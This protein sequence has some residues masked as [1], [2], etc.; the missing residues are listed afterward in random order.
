M[1]RIAVYFFYDKDG[2]VD[3]YVEYLLNDFKKNVD[4][5]IIVCN[6]KLN[7]QGKTSLEKFGDVIVRE[8]K[9]F[10]VWAY[11]TGLEYIGWDN[12]TN[13]DELILLNNTIYGPI[14]PFKDTFRK[15]EK[16]PEL[17]FWGLTIFFE[18]KEGDPF[19]TISCG[20]I[21]DHIQSHF[22]AIRKAMFTSKEFKEYWENMPMINNYIESV[23]VHE[24]I[25]TKHFED[26]GYKWDI[27]VPMKN[28][29]NYNCNPII[30]CPQKL[31]AEYSC[32][33]FKRRSF[34][35]SIDD[36]LRNN[37]GE[38]AKKLFDYIQYKTN[39]DTNMIWENIL[40]NYNH[41]D[42]Y[43]N[44][45]LTYTLP[46]NVQI[47][48]VNTKNAA[49]LCHIYFTDIL[50]YTLK[51]LKSIPRYFHLYI[52]TDTQDKKD[53]IQK[54][55]EELGFEKLSIVVI[56]NRGRDVSSFLIVGKQLMNDYDILCFVHDK[57]AEQTSPKT[58]GISFAYKCFEN[59]LS[60]E[61]YINNILATFESNPYLGLLCPPEPNHSV[62]YPA[63]GQEWRLNYKDVI[64]LSKKL[65][66][67]V[68]FDEQKPP[69]APYGTMF[70]VRP[71]AMKPLFDQNWKYDD[72]PEEPN[73][74]DGT[75]LHVI[76]RIYPFVVQQSGYY[77]AIGM[78]DKFAAIEYNNL[79]YY[80]RKFNDVM[81][82]EGYGPYHQ[83]MIKELEK[84][85]FE[86]NHKLIWARKFYY[87]S[88]KHFRKP[89][90][91]IKKILKGK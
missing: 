30:M 18:Y 47:K 60:N 69:I 4:K 75:L 86:Y 26:L 15:M 64:K 59:T 65:K 88:K 51:Y 21:P 67:N 36:S 81:F 16:R 83:E 38:E 3:S 13:Y 8:N 37:T 48:K 14:Y 53:K 77:S 34:F 45:N 20:Y 52:T 24:A 5:I 10:D 70:W 43:K 61:T 33:I 57:K 29:R 85:L 55:T 44:L 82:K 2:V 49:V 50:D 9:G 40:R 11:K 76:E 28:L 12:L 39:F 23:G 66:L 74:V 42:I 17:D 58:I 73:N 78:S 41:Y 62:Y 89:Y 19:G 32:P 35:H 87:F 63:I 1:K 91:I 71:K 6:G 31:L 25:F 27:S 84:A 46:T 80:L 56:P 54:E 90:H 72:F 79:R 22:I 68:P 7:I